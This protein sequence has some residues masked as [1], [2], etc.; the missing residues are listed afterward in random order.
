MRLVGRK[1]IRG[2][3]DSFLLDYFLC[4]VNIFY[5][6][7]VYYTVSTVVTRKVLL[8]TCTVSSIDVKVSSF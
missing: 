3:A 6:K 7:N 5:G 8:T 4:R 2:T 1:I